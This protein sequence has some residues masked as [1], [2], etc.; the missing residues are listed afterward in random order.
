[1]IG[2]KMCAV[3]YV[4]SKKEEETEMH[5]DVDVFCG[6]REDVKSKC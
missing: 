1:M 6:F 5:K 4:E 3:T 2:N